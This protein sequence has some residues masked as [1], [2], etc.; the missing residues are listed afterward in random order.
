MA[1]LNEKQRAEAK[2][3][4]DDYQK[5]CDMLHDVGRPTFTVSIQSD[6]DKDDFE[7]VQ[8]SVKGARALLE[9]E[10]I[11]TTDELKKLGIE[12]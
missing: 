8:V 4:L 1:K 10:K 2:A 7:E 6:R 3:L 12:V 11:W 5:I 9:A